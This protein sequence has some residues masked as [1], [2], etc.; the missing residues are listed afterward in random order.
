MKTSLLELLF[1]ERLLNHFDAKEILILC[2]ISTKKEIYHIKLDE[3]NSLPLG[4][5]KLAYESKGFMNEK[6]I[7]D[8]PLRGKA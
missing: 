3:K 8:F 6:T 1:P 7:Q 4:Y 5:D 2:D